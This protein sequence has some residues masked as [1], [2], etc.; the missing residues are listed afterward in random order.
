MSV[1]L[2]AFNGNALLLA[3]LALGILGTFIVWPVRR[4]SSPRDV[5]VVTFHTATDPAERHLVFPGDI[6]VIDGQEY[7]WDGEARTWVVVAR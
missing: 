1:P 6:W 3:L 7:C 4:R 2:Q 5:E